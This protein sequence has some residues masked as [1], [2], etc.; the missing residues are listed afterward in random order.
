[1]RTIT[2]TKMTSNEIGRLALEAMLLE[3]S[4]TPKPGLVDRN[5]SGAH[6]DMNFTTFMK[7]AASLAGSFVEFS[8]E[9]F[10]G[11]RD[12]I[13][14]SEVFPNVRKIGV[15]AEKNMFLATEGINTHKGEMFSLGLLSSCAGYLEGSGSEVT[16]DGVMRLAGEMCGGI[17]ERD[18]SGVKDKSPDCLTKGERVFLEHGITGIRGEAEAGYPTVRNV[19]LPALGEYLSEGLSVN[20]AMSMTLIHIMANA[21][22]TNIISRHDIKTAQEVMRT[23]GEMIESGFGLEDIRRLDDD[24]IERWISPGGSGDL[25]AVTYFVHSL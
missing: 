16:A 1:M 2:K 23:A 12:K 7:S 3:V 15:A 5:N 18:F 22:D 21:H 24:F 4:A 25:L 6:D 13:P 8:E 10:R 19:S 20:D 11:G 17:C 9:G 14:P